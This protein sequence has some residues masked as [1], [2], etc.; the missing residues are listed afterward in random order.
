M[1]MYIKVKFHNPH[2][3]NMVF[4]RITLSLQ[5]P[6]REAVWV[7]FHEHVFLSTQ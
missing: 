6:S 4:M 7:T 3:K 1:F 5:I 2:S